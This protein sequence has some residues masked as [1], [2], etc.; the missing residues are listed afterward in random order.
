MTPWAILTHLRDTLQ[1]ALGAGTSCRIGLE[2]NITAASYPLARLVPTRLLPPEE[3]G[4][5]RRRMQL[6]VYFGDHLLES[7]DGLDA[8]YAAL[9]AMETTIR[10]AVTLT[11]VQTARAAGQ[12]VR[13]VYV[14]T[15]ADEDRLPHYK[16]MASR[17][18][19]E[20]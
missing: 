20:G 5:R 16:L 6:T 1:T 2:A 13:A 4:G 8:V 7:A 17:F 14:D 9:L 15:I 3:V 10:D 11:A 18:E 12:Y 19:V